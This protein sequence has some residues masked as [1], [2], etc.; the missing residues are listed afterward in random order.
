MEAVLGRQVTALGSNESA[1]PLQIAMDPF[2]AKTSN[3]SVGRPVQT[4][5]GELIH[6]IRAK[7]PLLI[8]AG[9]AGTGKSLLLDMTARACASTGLSIRREGRGDLIDGVPNG[10][11]YDLLLI[12][13]AD[14]M[15]SSALQKLLADEGGCRPTTMVFMCLPNSVSRFAQIG[16][17]PPLVQLQPMSARDAHGYLLAGAT[18]M[19]RP[20]LFAAGTLDLIIEQS[21]G[22]PR[23]LRQNASLAFFSAAFEGCEQIYPQHASRAFESRAIPSIKEDTGKSLWRDGA[24][25]ELSKSVTETAHTPPEKPN[26]EKSSAEPVFDQGLALTSRDD[27]AKAQKEAYELQKMKRREANR[28]FSPWRVGK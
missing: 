16:N 7:H 4:A 15:P 22:S 6:Y 27:A 25:I 13:E 11:K 28:I 18:S 26:A 17:Y 1:G 2:A 24:A 3:L 5:L 12:D 21:S 20:D 14:V 19:G 8:V 10:K 23:L 9:A